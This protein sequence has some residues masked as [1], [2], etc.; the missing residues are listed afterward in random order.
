[1]FRQFIYTS[2]CISPVEWLV[3]EGSSGGSGS[4]A[5]VAEAPPAALPHPQTLVHLDLGSG[6]IL[7]G[8]H[9]SV[10]SQY[11]ELLTYA[12]I[13]LHC[14]HSTP[15]GYPLK[16]WILWESQGGSIPRWVLR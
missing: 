6:R 1:M 10:L 8:W 4:K 13:A 15:E 5:S 7:V 16:R 9:W 2:V 14:G 11:G 12:A 3:T